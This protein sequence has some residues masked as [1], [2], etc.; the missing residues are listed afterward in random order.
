MKESDIPLQ[1]VQRSIGLQG[2]RDSLR[3]YERLL[4]LDDLSEKIQP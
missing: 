2:I 4:E 1:T 3:P